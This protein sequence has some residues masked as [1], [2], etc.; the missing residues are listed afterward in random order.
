MVP[1]VL[2]IIARVAY[3]MLSAFAASRTTED[4]KVEQRDHDA[5]VL[6][7]SR[8]RLG[9][10]FYWRKADRARRLADDPAHLARLL[11]VLASVVEALN[12]EPGIGT[13]R[14]RASVRTLRGRCSDADTDAALKLLGAG[15]FVDIGRQGDR[16]Y[17]LDLMY[18]PK[19][20]RAYLA[21]QMPGVEFATVAVT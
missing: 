14:L 17:T 16:H 3:L 8:R 4:G 9:P 2:L 5:L 20:V 15:V 6:G 18:A 12:A 13:R 11:P 1:H 19:A 10:G 21:A 7:M